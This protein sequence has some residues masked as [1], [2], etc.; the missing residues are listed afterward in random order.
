MSMLAQAV[1]LVFLLCQKSIYCDRKKVR[2]ECPGFF[3]SDYLT[4]HCNVKP[5][6]PSINASSARLPW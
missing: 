6:I 4:E 1:R 2:S 5:K 3:D